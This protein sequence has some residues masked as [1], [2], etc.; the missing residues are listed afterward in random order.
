M[1][2]IFETVS[3]GKLGVSLSFRCLKS[4]YSSTLTVFRMGSNAVTQLRLKYSWNMEFSVEMVR[5]IF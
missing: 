3:Y 1:K 2:K 4:Q 5:L